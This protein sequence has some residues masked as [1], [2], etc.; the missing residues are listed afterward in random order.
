MAVEAVV[1]VAAAAGDDDDVRVHLPPSAP[2][3]DA[4]VCVSREPHSGGHRRDAGAYGS[5]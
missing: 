3:G 2:V 1:A 4:E 5:T